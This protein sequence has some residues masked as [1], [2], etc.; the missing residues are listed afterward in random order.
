MK[1]SNSGIQKWED[2]MLNVWKNIH[3]KSKSF[4]MIKNWQKQWLKNL[5]KLLKQHFMMTIRYYVLYMFYVL[6][7]LKCRFDPIFPIISNMLLRTLSD[8][9]KRI[10]TIQ[11]WQLK[12]QSF[13]ELYFL[14]GIFNII[15]C[16]QHVTIPLCKM[17]TNKNI[18]TQ[19]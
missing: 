8:T 11:R 15:C 6:Y 14:N 1:E 10:F 2:T 3:K 12:L 16:Q 17:Y 5:Q 13:L 18:R 19:L 9:T 7:M 4:T